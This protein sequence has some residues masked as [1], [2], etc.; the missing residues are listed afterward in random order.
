MLCKTAKDALIKIRVDLL[1]DRPH[2]GQN[3]QLQGTKGCYESSRGGRWD[4][5]KIWLSERD[6]ANVWTELANFSDVPELAEK[7]LPA[8][9]RDA[10]AAAKRAGHGGGDYFEMVDFVGAIRGESEPV[11]GIH[12]SMDM[13]LP[14]LISQKSIQQDGKWL[15]VPDSREW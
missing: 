14:G 13:T 3:Y 8:R 10:S 2:A 11:L 4:K 7:Y 9:W 1:S 15:P 6:A 12:E 5:D